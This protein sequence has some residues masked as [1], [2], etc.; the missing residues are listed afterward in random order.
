M[1]LWLVAEFVVSAAMVLWLLAEYRVV[2]GL[3]LLRT[4]A[5]AAAVLIALPALVGVG[6]RRWWLVLAPAAALLVAVPL[7]VAGAFPHSGEPLPPTS[8]ALLGVML[9]A[10]PATAVGVAAGKLVTRLGRG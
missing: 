5:G 4:D 2:E 6:V 7:E 10:C 8:G 3:G 1:P 9:I